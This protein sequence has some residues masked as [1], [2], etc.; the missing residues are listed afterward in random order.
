MAAS[1]IPAV[2]AALRASDS[3]AAAAAVRRVLAATTDW[4]QSGSATA[5]R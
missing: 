1:R 5:A 4:P 2:K 3:D